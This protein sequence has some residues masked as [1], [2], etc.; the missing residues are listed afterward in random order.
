MKDTHLQ[1]EKQWNIIRIYR[2]LHLNILVRNFFVGFSRSLLPVK[3]LW[4]TKEISW[5]IFVNWHAPYSI[6]IRCL[7]DALA[8]TWL[9][10]ARMQIKVTIT[11][12]M[13]VYKLRQFD[14]SN[15]LFGPITKK[16]KSNFNGSIVI[17][18]FNV[19][20]FNWLK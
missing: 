4:W 9:Y 17:A 16:S 13:R 19:W 14:F 18:K 8:H 5:I 1:K 11:D 15:W 7:F 6:F 12:N 10:I 3:Q 2:W 20:D